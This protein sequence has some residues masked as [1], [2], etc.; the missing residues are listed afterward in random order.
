MKRVRKVISLLAVLCMV[1]TMNLTAFATSDATPAV[2]EARNGIIK[3]RLYYVDNAG[4]SYCLQ[5]GSGF[6]L[7]ASSGATTVITNYHV[8][9]LEDEEKQ[10]YS[11]LFAVD[12][13][14]ANEVNLEARVAVKRDVEIVTA[15][16]NGSEETDF[17]ILELEDY[18]YGERKCRTKKPAVGFYVGKQSVFELAGDN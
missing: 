10:A 3:V 16:V 9:A 6:L 12:F 2:A 14:N 15:Y 5:T 1:F 17:A 18:I 7:G 8:I 13:F 11:E 4:N